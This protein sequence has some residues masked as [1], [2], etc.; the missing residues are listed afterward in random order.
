MR[1]GP[2]AGRWFFGAFDYGH[3]QGSDKGCRRCPRPQGDGG[4]CLCSRRSFCGEL[5]PCELS[6]HLPLTLR[7]IPFGGPRKSS[8]SNATHLTP[9]RLARRDFPLTKY[10]SLVIIDGSQYSF[11]SCPRSAGRQCAL[12]PDGAPRDFPAHWQ[13]LLTRI[14][15]EGVSRYASVRRHQIQ[16]AAARSGRR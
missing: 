14:V 5:W 4:G 16:G 3:G 11:W 7:S 8:A 10:M 13:Q 9:V 1:G 6:I 12:R 2:L 15:T